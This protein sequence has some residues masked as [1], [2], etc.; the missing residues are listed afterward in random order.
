MIR[1]PQSRDEIDHDAGIIVTA[2]Q[3]GQARIEVTAIKALI[4]QRLD[5]GYTVRRIWLELSGQGKISVAL[6]NFYVQVQKIQREHQAEKRSSAPAAPVLS[7]AV[8]TPRAATASM[9]G[10]D[11]SIPK[12]HH[13]PVSGPLVVTP[14]VEDAEQREQDDHAS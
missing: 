11:T 12:F 5:E 4:L 3:W 6:S 7:R 8:T 9:R 1:N 10:A 2:N 13:D 14:A